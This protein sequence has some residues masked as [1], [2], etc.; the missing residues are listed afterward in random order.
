MRG[1][2]VEP[3]GKA[4][5]RVCTCESL[6]FTVTRYLTEAACEGHGLFWFTV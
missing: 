5:P 1:A 3:V 2:G 6:F 4:F